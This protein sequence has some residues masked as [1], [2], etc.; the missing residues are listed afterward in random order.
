MLVK[1]LEGANE[2][3]AILQDTSHSIVN[4]LQHLAA[5]SHSLEGVRNWSSVC[6]QLLPNSISS[7]AC[8]NPNLISSTHPHSHLYS[9]IH[10]HHF[11]I[12]TKFGPR[13]IIV[14]YRTFYFSEFLHTFPSFCYF[15]PNRFPNPIPLQLSTM[16]IPLFPI[17]IPNPTFLCN[18]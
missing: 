7:P 15:L 13:T 3:S 10:S 9:R 14:L 5:L 6:L 2:D 11:K 12:L 1:S 16:L 18:T 17:L 8:N 4:V